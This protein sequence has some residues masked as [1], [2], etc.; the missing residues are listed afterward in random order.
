MSPGDY[1]GRTAAIVAVMASPAPARLRAVLQTPATRHRHDLDAQASLNWRRDPARLPAGL[2]LQWLGT[3]GFRLSFAG[4]SLLID[5]YVTRHGLRTVLGRRPLVTDPRLVSHLL[6]DADAV[7]VGHTHFDHALDVPEVARR[8]GC[9]VYGS[10][11]LRTLMGL[12]G[13]ATQAVVVEAHRTYGIGPFEVTFVPSRH[14]KLLAG[15][16][17]PAGGELTCE[18][19]DGLDA[20]A[21]R[22]GQVWG[23]HVAVAGTTLYHQGSADLLDEE[24]APPRYRGIDYFLCGIAGRLFTAGY[25]RRV[26][27]LLEP[28]VVVPQHH[29]NFFRGLDSPMGFSPNVNLARFPDEVAAVSRDFEVR[30]L[31]PL[32]TV[33][34]P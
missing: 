29:D 4:H 30:V 27:R 16:A 9:P 14:S 18:S 33:A 25:T 13:L 34:G 12:H 3:A 23:I 19:L 17:V 2:E 10:T 26:L 32:Q 22:C 7:L 24:L 11:S 28:R 8:S 21:F 15:L 6:P 31:D 20:G 1:E 5:P